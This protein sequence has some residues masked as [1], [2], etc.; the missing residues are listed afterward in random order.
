MTYNSQNKP[1]LVAA[2]VPTSQKHL[3]NSNLPTVAA[4]WFVPAP[5]EP[6]RDRLRRITKR[7]DKH[8]TQTPPGPKILTVTIS[9]F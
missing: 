9:G 3:T 8:I 6:P 2:S 4:G 1:R 7:P 5:F